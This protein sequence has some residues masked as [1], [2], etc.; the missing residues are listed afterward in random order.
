MPM[1]KQTPKRSTSPEQARDEATSRRVTTT[2]VGPDGDVL[3]M[4]GPA[5]LDPKDAALRPFIR[6][7]ANMI[8]ADILRE[9]TEKR[10]H[11]GAK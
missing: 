4:Q 8:Y 7:L 9:E 3:I 2:H 11:D 6:A 5:E 10:R 1:K